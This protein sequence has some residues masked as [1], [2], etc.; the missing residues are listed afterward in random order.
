MPLVR[1][2][3]L[4]TGGVVPYEAMMARLSALGF[5]PLPLLAR[6]GR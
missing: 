2:G 4:D 5:D 1:Y 3:I 6:G